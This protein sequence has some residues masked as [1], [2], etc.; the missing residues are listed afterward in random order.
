MFGRR[1]VVAINDA[2]AIA[3]QPRRTSRFQFVNHRLGTLGR[4]TH[5]RRRDAQFHAL[6]F[7]VNRVVGDRQK[8]LLFPVCGEH[9]WLSTQNNRLHQIDDRR[10]QQVSLILLNGSPSKQVIE[11][12][13]V[14]KTMHNGSRHDTDGALFNKRSECSCNHPCRPR[15]KIRKACENIV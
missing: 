5:D 1:Q 3:W 13:V 10:E 4:I 14:E 15:R 9:R 8:M 7:V 2:S 11:V 6:E 12:I